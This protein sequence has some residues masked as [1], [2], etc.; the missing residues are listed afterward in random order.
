MRVKLFAAAAL[1]ASALTANAATVT[2]TNLTALWYDASPVANLTAN[3][4]TAAN[5]Q[6]R[7]GGAAND[8]ST[9]SGYNFAVIDPTSAIVP[10]TPSAD[11]VLGSFAHVNF[12]VPIP[13]ITEV[14]LRISADV[15]VDGTGVGNHN[16]VFQF[17]HDETS[18]GA[19]GDV[20]PYG[21][22]VVGTVGSIN[23]N[24]CADR[25]TVDFSAASDS[26]LIGTDLYT[27]NVRGFDAGAGLTNEFLTKESSVNSAR[28]IAQVTLR[29]SIHIPE[30]GSVAL[31][32][33]GLVGLTLLRRRAV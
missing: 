6:I 16:F 18:N 7:W 23:E 9:G 2:L 22:G 14:K 20:C 32:G 4:G 11:F 26:F 33:L 12:P 1:A 13:T 17:M 3:S 27:I 10:P 28:L 31:V 29:N 8:F 5:A 19:A 21:S 25:V 15:D 30:P 24:G